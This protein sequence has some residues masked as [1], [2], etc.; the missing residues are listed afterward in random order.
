ME[1]H[2]ASPKGWLSR[3]LCFPGLMLPQQLQPYYRHVDWLVLATVIQLQEL[4]RLLPQLPPLPQVDQLLQQVQQLLAQLM[5]SMPQHIMPQQPQLQQLN[6]LMQTLRALLQL[7]LQQL[8]PQLQP[9]MMEELQLREQE[10]L[11]CEHWLNHDIQPNQV[12]MIP[13]DWFEA[14][15]PMIAQFKLKLLVL[16]GKQGTEDL[17]G[18]PKTTLIHPRDAMRRVGDVCQV[19]WDVKPNKLL[20][21]W[22]GWEDAE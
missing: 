4:E 13:R 10:L 21:I 5:H 15:G 6:R 8:R 20:E 9:Q 19:L 1:Q 17:H 2:K 7:Q 18:F 16:C 22:E 14:L 3:A 11:R 12:V